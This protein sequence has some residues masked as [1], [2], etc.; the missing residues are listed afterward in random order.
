MRVDS[1]TMLL[2]VLSGMYLGLALSDVVHG[3][4]SWRNI[5]M[6]VFA[7]VMFFSLAV[8]RI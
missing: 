7:G 1:Y 2:L 8:I 5:F 3:R 4:G 6:L